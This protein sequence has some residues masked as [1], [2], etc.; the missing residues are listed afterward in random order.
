MHS[1]YITV[2]LVEQST[3]VFWSV[4]KVAVPSA[5]KK[6]YTAIMSKPDNVHRQSWTTL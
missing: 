4:H 6:D 2:D 5:R 1:V 3:Q